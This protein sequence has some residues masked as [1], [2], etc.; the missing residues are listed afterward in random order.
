MHPFTNSR[1]Q[2][3]F[4][5]IQI[6]LN[7]SLGNWVWATEKRIM[8][9]EEKKNKERG[10]GKRTDSSIFSEKEKM[11]DLKET[12]NSES[13]FPILITES[14]S[15]P[16]LWEPLTEGFLWSSQEVLLYLFYQQGQC[17]SEISSS[18]P[19]FT[20]LVGSRA[21]VWANANSKITVYFITVHWQKN[22]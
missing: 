22:K 12:Q 3:H 13:G 16:R 10:E 21:R 1:K 8:V 17:R 11:K 18:M 15:A 7:N 5:Y 4:S 2:K 19:V 6:L 14:P 20:Y 9:E